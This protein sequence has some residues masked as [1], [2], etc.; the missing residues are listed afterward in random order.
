MVE[1]RIVS[2]ALSKCVGKRC[3]LILQSGSRLVDEI[4]GIRFDLVILDGREIGV[5]RC[6][7]LRDRSEIAIGDIAAIETLEGV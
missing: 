4:A 5:P 2:H 1:G 6:M 7:V 3:S